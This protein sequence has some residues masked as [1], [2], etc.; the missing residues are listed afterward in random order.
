MNIDLSKEINKIEGFK[1]LQEQLAKAYAKILQI[2]E[3]KAS[4]LISAKFNKHV[5]MLSDNLEKGIT[6]ENLKNLKRSQD[7]DINE[8]LNE[9]PVIKG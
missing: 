2:D 6:E 8:Y 5:S 4:K 3:E 1:E 9:K 7:V